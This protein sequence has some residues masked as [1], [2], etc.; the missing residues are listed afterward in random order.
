MFEV[1]IYENDPLLE[2]EKIFQNMTNRER[3]RD[4]LNIFLNKKSVISDIY[5][6]QKILERKKKKGGN[7]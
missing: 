7:F 2:K 6:E 4:Y 3:D 1:K 5:K